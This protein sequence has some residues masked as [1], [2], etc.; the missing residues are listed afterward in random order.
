[1]K[2]RKRIYYT[3]EQKA[4]I[5][6][7]YKQGD[8]LH[9]IAR[10]FDRYHSSIMPTIYQTGGFRPPVRKRHRLSLSLDEREEISRG[11]AE[12]CSIREIA[13]KISRA[14]STVS[15]EIRR[16]G[17]LTNYRAV[18]ADK[19][20]WDNALRPKAC[21]LSKNA[22]LCKIIAEKM[23]QGWPPEQIAGWLKRNYPDAQEMHVS[24]ETIYKTLFIQTRGALK[25]ELQ[26]YLRSRRTVRKSRTTSLKGK[27]LGSIPN[28]VPISERPPTVAD[29][30]VPGH[31]E[32]DLIQGSKNSYIVTLVERHSR[33]V[34]L[35][36]ISDN[37][38]ITVISALI[39]QAQK[40][41]AELY[42]TLTW[43]RGVEMTNHTVFTV[44]T[45]IQVYFCDPQSPWQR[46][47]NENT[48]RLLRQYFPKGTDLSVHSQQRLNS[49][50]RQLNERPRKTLDYESPAERFNQCVASI[51]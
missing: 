2:P 22:T 32:G 49:V 8:S 16:H 5:W 36:K 47:S 18:K 20:A 46:G 7:R 4:I 39:K 41:P 51:G 34:M 1:M 21:K 45:D 42:K 50:A 28:A 10:M 38:T 27:G 29:R 12:K 37:K 24:H 19:T 13:K 48:N 44:A 35:A 26:Q 31:W 43:D 33:Y 23:H 15:R 14:P 11:L 25:K 40:L 17:G 9:E 30:A 6:D 3:P